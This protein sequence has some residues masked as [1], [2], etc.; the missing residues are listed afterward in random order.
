MFDGSGSG[1]VLMEKVVDLVTGMS[2]DRATMRR[3]CWVG[4]GWIGLDW[5]LTSNENVPL[6]DDNNHKVLTGMSGRTIV[7]PTDWSCPTSMHIALHELAHRLTDRLTQ[8]RLILGSTDQVRL[9]LKRAYEFFPGGLKDRLKKE[10]KR[11]WDK[12]HSQS[13]LRV[14]ADILAAKAVAVADPKSLLAASK[15]ADLEERLVQLNELQKVPT[16]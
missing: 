8:C 1:D 11:R 2:I 16:V 7:F 9:G 3:A 5:T 6:T 14:K 4:L 15:V 12:C 13:V 10:R